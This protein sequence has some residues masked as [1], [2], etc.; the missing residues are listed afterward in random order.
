V[1]PGIYL[2]TIQASEDAFCRVF[3]LCKYVMAETFVKAAA[4]VDKRAPLPGGLTDFMRKINLLLFINLWI[5][6]S[7]P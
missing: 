3:K 4:F 6:H 7:L 2:N 1:Q 5:V